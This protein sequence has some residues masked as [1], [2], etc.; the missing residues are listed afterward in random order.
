MELLHDRARL[1]HKYLHVT[2]SRIQTHFPDLS[3][4]TIH[5]HAHISMM[6]RRNY[7]VVLILIEYNFFEEKGKPAR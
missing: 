7:M 3:T 1:Y 2:I 4:H 6:L 5:A